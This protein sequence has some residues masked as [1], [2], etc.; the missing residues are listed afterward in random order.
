M[1]D[2]LNVC[3][4]QSKKNLIEIYPQFIIGHTNDLMIRG[5]DF[6]AVWD[7]ERHIWSTDESD[8]IRLIDNELKKAADKYV[9]TG[10]EKVRVLYLR[11]SSS[12]MIDAFHK[13]CQ[14]QMRD[15]FHELDENVIFAN[16]IPVPKKRY[17][18]RTLDYS[19]EEGDY[20]AWDKLVGT[21]YRP[22][23][24]KK[25]EWA[26]GAIVTGDSKK[27]QKFLVFYGSAG[28]GKSTILNIIQE[29]FDGYCSVFDAK[30]LGSS[31]NSFAL[32]AF[33]NNPLVA[34]QHD[35]DLSRIEDNTRLN[36]LV[37]H[38]P[39][40]VNEKF[41]STYSSK[42]NAFL[43]MGTNKPVKITDAKSGLIRRLIDVT[44]SGDKLDF[45]VYTDLMDK[46]KFELGAIAY[47][48][49]KVYLSNK[50]AYDRYIPTV[51]LSAS[52]DFYN[53]VIEEFEKFAN[54]EYVTLKMAW[55]LYKDYCEDANV[56]YK[57]TRRT[58]SEE[59]KNY[60]REYYDRYRSADGGRPRNVYVGFKT[61]KFDNDFLDETVNDE[62]DLVKY[63][64][65]SLKEQDSIFDKQFADC[66]A[67]YAT[68]DGVPMKK[69]A[70]VKTKLSDID[71]HKLHYVKPPENYICIDFDIKDKDGNKSLELNAKA[72]SKWP[73]TYAE[74]S[75]GGQGIHLIYLYAGD[76]SKLSAVYDKDIEVK[77][78]KGNS[79]LRRRLSKCNNEQILKINSG[80][81]LKEDKTTMINFESIKSEKSLRRRIEK[82]LRKE[83]HANT[84][85]NID[86]IKM[87][88]D[89]AYEQGLKY[90]VSDM[91]ALITT[92]ASRST[93]QSEYCLNQVAKMHFKS[94]EP[95]EDISPG[96]NKEKLVFFDVEVF[97][98]LFVVCW[99]FEGDHQPVH[100]MINPTPD[101]IY[102]FIKFK[103]V[104]FNCRRYDNHILYARTMGYSNMDLYNLS[105]SIIQD[106]TGF[107][108]EAYNLSY[109]DV[110][111][112][113]SKKQ[114]LKK[115]EI[116]LGINHQ[117][118]E[119]PW[120]QPVPEDK[121]D[122]VAKYCANDVM[123]T[124]AVFNA[125]HADFLAREILAALAGQ[126]VNASTNSQTTRMIFGRD[127]NPQRQF[128]YR[129]MGGEDGVK[130]KPPDG[131]DLAYPEYTVFDDKGRCIFPGYKYEAGKSTYRGEVVGEGG[132]VYAEPG[133]YEHAAV[134]DVASMHPHSIIAENLFGDIYTKH[135]KDLVDARIAIKHGDFDKAKEM[136]GGKLAPYL[137][138]EKSAKDLS[139]ALKIA[140]NSVYGLTAA[141]FSNPFKDPRNIDNIV[142]KRGA[143]FMINLKHEVQAKGFTVA[144]IK[145]DSIK[146]PNATPDILKFVEEYGKLYGYTFEHESTYNRVCLVNNAVL[147]GLVE[148][149]D[150]NKLE[151]PYWEAVGKEFQIPYVFKT[152]FTKEP[153]EFKDMCET[154]T[155]QTS[156]YLDFNEGLPEGEHKYNFVGRVGEFTPI[157]PGFGGGILL[158][159]SG[160]DSDGNP[161]YASATGAK[162]YRWLESL[163]VKS[164][165][166]ESAIDTSYFNK[167]VDTAKD[168]ISKFTDIEWFVSND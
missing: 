106:H 82:A 161:K 144:H 73:R 137:T 157:K 80:L 134:M 149:T 151:K 153:I 25:I 156:L 47:H 113:S 119:I 48:C 122:L 79:S 60:F 166:K 46:I 34:I 44:P 29:M 38:E 56:K 146:I 78:Q 75:Q 31:N 68:K 84:K 58:F 45:A 91:H 117:E 57:L 1:L 142:A 126:T 103:L 3:S 72:A 18:S 164:L 127:K 64:I 16:E 141:K 70:N 111:D 110:Y 52:N 101:E 131:I 26:I 138:D 125:R 8:A 97:K 89:K 83:V 155:V 168:E 7:E 40:T 51:M 145:T 159:Y 39:M 13:F 160:E 150:G 128:N 154:K 133:C 116:E 27:I 15:T 65:D 139:K 94:D 118:L 49:K 86:F 55:S 35:G 53:Y 19:L 11:I 109:T 81:P 54:S 43:F 95:N 99:K 123:A 22:E 167:Q 14:R 129:F 10:N 41:K 114:S 152:L 96:D 24:R 148:E 85:P 67:Q 130:Y 105:Q 165:N 66:P 61:D 90:D 28:T 2:F 115:F 59:L 92:F 98:N 9:P 23:E 93:H 135:F 12:G 63:W 143:L 88:L 107:H 147:V 87:I 108:M 112:F 77:V 120:D 69:W 4:R 102:D 33:K 32:E 76:A 37:S 6:Y 140:I 17:A 21:L 36:S 74:V 124:E 132:Y 158:R 30:A 20:S 71:T 50:H 42:F 104:G 5:S 163:T 136:L 100:K 162:G 62:D 121:W